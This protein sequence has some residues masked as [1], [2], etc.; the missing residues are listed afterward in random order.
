MNSET[1][2]PASGDP[3][4][5]L[6]HP[7]ELAGHVEPP[8]GRQLLAALR[9]ER[10]LV[11]SDCQGD[12][13]HARVDGH[14]QVQ[15]DLHGLTQQ[16]QVAVLDVPPVLAEMD[17]DPIGATQLGEDRSPDRVGFPPAPGLPERGHMINIDA[18]PRHERISPGVYDTMVRNAQGRPPPRRGGCPSGLPRPTGRSGALAR[19]NVRSGPTANAT[20]PLRP[21]PAPSTATIR[22]SPYSGWSTETPGWKASRS[23]GPEDDRPGAALA[24]AEVRGGRQSERRRGGRAVLRRRGGQFPPEGRGRTS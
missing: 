2:I 16:A 19:M 12:V 22:P 17:G 7:I 10:H 5:G 15:P 1:S 11:G 9:H 21:G 4:G 8:L 14:L 13:D 24:A 6:R 23:T 18:Q 3:P 20:R